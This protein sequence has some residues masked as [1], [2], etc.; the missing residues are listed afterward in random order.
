MEFASFG[1]KGLKSLYYE[2]CSRGVPQ[3][4]LGKIRRLLTAM[5]AARDLEDLKV[6]PGWRLHPLQGG[7]ADHWSLTVTGNWRIVFQY[8]TDE[9][10]ASKV[11]LLDYHGS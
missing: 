2:D 5:E 1:H 8:D 6:F 9:N 3:A 7:L 11:D 4:M 10:T